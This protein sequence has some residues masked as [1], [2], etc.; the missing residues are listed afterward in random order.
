[1]ILCNTATGGINKIMGSW[2]N[3]KTIRYFNDGYEEPAQQQGVGN[4][5]TKVLKY[6]LGDPNPQWLQERRSSAKPPE[7]TSKPA[8]KKKAPKK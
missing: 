4:V 8:V 2:T 3:S 5:S 6:P 1:M 7:E